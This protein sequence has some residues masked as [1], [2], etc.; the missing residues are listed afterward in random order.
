MAFFYQNEQQNKDFF[1]HIYSN[2]SK[3]DLDQIIHDRL[4]SAG[5]SIKEGIPGNGT[6]SKG[7]RTMRLIF[8]AFVKYFK[9]R[10][11]TN[12]TEQGTVRAEFRKATSGMSGG[13]IGMNQVKKELNYLSQLMTSI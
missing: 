13:L 2:C 6:Y 7:N 9:L 10:I 3:Q 11:F 12:Q 5:Y 8:G 1:A 4:I